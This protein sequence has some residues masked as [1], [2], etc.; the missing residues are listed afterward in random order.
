MRATTFPCVA[1]LVAVV[2]ALSMSP[3]TA[4]LAA[5]TAATV[6]GPAA[7]AEALA[8]ARFKLDYGK[9]SAFFRAARPSAARPYRSLAGSL[10]FIFIS[11]ISCAG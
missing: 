2:T 8:F 6:T 4:A 10:I 7:A 1:I 9:R 5:G 3:V 11:I